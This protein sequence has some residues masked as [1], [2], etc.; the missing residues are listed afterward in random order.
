MLHTSGLGRH[1]LLG[2]MHIKRGR[3]NAER[4]VR[5]G[6]RLQQELGQRVRRSKLEHEIDMEPTVSWGKAARYMVF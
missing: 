5:S 2:L 4:I 3:Q 1:E 6:Q